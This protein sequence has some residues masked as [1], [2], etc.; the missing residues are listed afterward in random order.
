MTFSNGLLG[1]KIGENAWN[2]RL[3]AKLRNEGFHSADFEILFPTL[4]GLRK[5]DVSFAGERGIV[6]ISGKLGERQEV[7]AIVTAQEYQQ[8]ISKIGAVQESLAV[9]YPSRTGEFF[10]L[11]A[12]ATDQH[13]SLPWACKTLEEVVE[14]IVDLTKENWEK[15]KL[16]LESSV[17]AAIRVLRAGVGDYSSKLTTVHLSAVEQ[18]FGGTEFFVSLL[19]YEKA[20]KNKV[21]VMKAAAAY[22]FLNQVMFYEILAHETKKYPPIAEPDYDK[23]TSLKPKYFD[24]VLQIDYRPIF[25][26]DVAGALT[27]K[28]IGEASGKIVRAVKALFP[29]KVDHDIVG[30]I[31]HNIIPLDLRKLVAAFFTN[32]QAG[33]LH[34]SRLIQRMRE[35]SI[36][37]VEAAPSLFQATRQKRGWREL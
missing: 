33:D 20:Q 15:A 31:F 36:Q 14:K 8:T 18:V 27:D 24:A 19:G 22:L 16:G 1:G 32:V 3:A 4:R 17:S 25:A 30:K 29:G 28:K 21:Q 2:S 6:V 10:R 26:F 7:D 9:T 35:F 5:P 23:P 11:R 13:D 34:K 37:H 12:L